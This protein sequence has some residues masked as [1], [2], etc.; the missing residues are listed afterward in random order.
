MTWAVS[1]RGTFGVVVRRY[2]IEDGPAVLLL[3]P[4]PMLETFTPCLASNCM[5]LTATTEREARG[6]ANL[7]LE[8]R[9]REEEERASYREKCRV[10]VERG[11][12]AAMEAQEKYEAGVVDVQKRKSTAEIVSAMFWGFI[13]T[14]AISMGFFFLLLVLQGF[15]LYTMGVAQ[16]KKLETCFT[17]CKAQ[18]GFVQHYSLRREICICELMP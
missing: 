17:S 3:R 14:P 15:A 12:K 6:A 9:R 1:K 2:T 10:E 7:W 8:A 11:K 4:G 13:K 5:E 16:E 18:R